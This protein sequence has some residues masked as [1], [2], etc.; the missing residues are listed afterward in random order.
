VKRSKLKN[1]VK[2]TAA[3]LVL[4]IAG[5]LFSQ[6]GSDPALP[7]LQNGDR[8]LEQGKYKEALVEYQKA[9]GLSPNNQYARTQ[10]SQLKE[11]LGLADDNAQVEILPPRDYSKL[12]VELGP[13]YK[14]AANKIAIKYPKGWS[15]DNG[16]PSFD[17][18]FIETFSE[19]YIFVK[20]VPM[21][22]ALAMNTQFKTRMQAVAASLAKSVP[23]STVRYCNFEKLGNLTALRTEILFK[24]GPNNAL[25][26]CRLIPDNN[27]IIIV[28]YVCQEKLY[29][30]FRPLLESSV[31]TLTLNPR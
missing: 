29:Y 3:A 12:S 30:T 9:L 14:D 26:V 19:A 10:V 6:Q 15:I 24:A 1:I 21:N 28:S 5:A 8:F 16:D 11:K 22:E 2:L 25:I 4:L 20:V 31:G 27:R 13:Y 18:K 7:Y 17:V 23:N